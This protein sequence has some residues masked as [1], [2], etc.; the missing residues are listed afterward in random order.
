MACPTRIRYVLPWRR[1][2]LCC[3]KGAI[4]DKQLRPAV[5]RVLL[6][7]A[8]AGC[9]LRGSC[10]MALPAEAATLTY[11]HKRV[12]GYTSAEHA[13][14]P[15]LLRLRAAHSNIIAGAAKPSNRGSILQT[16]MQ[17]ARACTDFRGYDELRH[18]AS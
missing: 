15:Q 14:R 17:E 10:G 18:C 5:I 7:N 16:R 13:G 3:L 1:L 6:E 8:R 11:T 2:L 9:A 4:E 12:Y